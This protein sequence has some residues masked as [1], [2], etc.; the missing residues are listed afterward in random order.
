MQNG[1]WFHVP[2][3]EK[4]CWQPNNATGTCFLYVYKDGVLIDSNLTGTA[5]CPIKPSSAVF[6]NRFSITVGTNS[7]ATR[8]KIW[9]RRR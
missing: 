6:G 2:A 3:T 8:L 5:T 1:A 4:M 7:H 9:R